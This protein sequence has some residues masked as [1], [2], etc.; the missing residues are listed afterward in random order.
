MKPGP[1]RAIAVLTSVKNL[2]GDHTSRAGQAVANKAA[3]AQTGTPISA[4]AVKFS[5]EGHEHPSTVPLDLGKPATA[6]WQRM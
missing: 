2:L 1:M 3:G 4:Y 6:D 5:G